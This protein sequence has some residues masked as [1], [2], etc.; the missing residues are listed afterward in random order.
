MFGKV[1]PSKRAS[2]ECMWTWDGAQLAAADAHWEVVWENR[3]DV[4]DVGNACLMTG[5]EI[6][7]AVQ[8]ITGVFAG[9]G[10]DQIY[11]L[12]RR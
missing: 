7:A 3:T 12:E 8:A 11:I 4:V 10:P 1:I 9:K 5:L 2:M 6:L